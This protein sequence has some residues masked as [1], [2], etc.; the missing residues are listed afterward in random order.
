MIESAFL[1]FA[2]LASILWGSAEYDLRS[3][4]LLGS[5]GSRPSANY[6]SAGTTSK[7]GV[8]FAGGVTLGWDISSHENGM[9]K[10]TGEL[11]LFFVQRRYDLNAPQIGVSSLALR[12]VLFPLL[13]RHE[14]P[15]KFSVGAGGFAYGALGSVHTKTKTVSGKIYSAA[16]PYG[17]TAYSPG[18]FGVALSIDRG[19]EINPVLGGRID[20]RFHYGLLNQSLEPGK[21]FH[22]REILLLLGFSYG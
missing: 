9:R 10:W 15:A 8:G 1:P 18:E 11:G 6:G 3:S 21:E 22:T 7:F 17:Q 13:I 14:L 2:A 20:L 5:N 12:G 16:A 19:F 4:V